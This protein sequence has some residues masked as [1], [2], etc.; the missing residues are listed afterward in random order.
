ML[1]ACLIGAN[2]ERGDGDMTRNMALVAGASG[3]IGKGVVEAV[4]ADADWRFRSLASRPIDGAIRSS[5]TS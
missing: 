5:P 2:K 4:T 1:R 3:I